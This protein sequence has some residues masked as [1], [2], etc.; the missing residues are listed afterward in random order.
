MFSLTYLKIS[1]VDIGSEYFIRGV[2]L[3]LSLEKKRK[4][5]TNTYKI[6]I[7][8]TIAECILSLVQKLATF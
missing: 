2:F 5:I 3:I 8:Y 6:I 4:H 1:E 7:V